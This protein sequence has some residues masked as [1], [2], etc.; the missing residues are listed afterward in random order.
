M[1]TIFD[2]DGFV[3]ENDCE[4]LKKAMKG[5]GT[6]E[7]AIT[8]NLAN[9]SYKQRQETKKKY[10]QMFGKRLDEE[11]ET[12]LSGNFLKLVL[13]LLKDKVEYDAWVLHD[14]MKGVGT[15]ESALIEIMCSRSNNEIEEIKKLYKTKYKDELVKDLESDTGGNFKRLM[16]SLSQAAR[17]ESD[18][19]DKSKA[20]NDAKALY[21]AG[22]AK[23]GTDESRFNVILASRNYAQLN[24]T[25]EEYLKISGKDIEE[26]IR[27][28]MSGDIKEGMLAIVE[29]CRDKPVF[30]A[31]QLYKSM[32]GFGT[33]DDQLIRIVVSRSEIDLEDI[34]V[35]F[36]AEYGQTLDAFIDGDTS[37]DYKKLLRRICMG[38]K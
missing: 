30:F 9:R 14:A 19:V 38:N 6:N 23:W 26:T 34:K 13:A 4:L 31:Q 27:S 35:C 24:E 29:C 21:D 10:P 11:L 17:D 2:F 33:N 32:K 28:E 22:A 36:K 15:K 16:V 25:F 1:A 37:G 7:D 5:L 12:E 3:V 8:E 18:S 20:V